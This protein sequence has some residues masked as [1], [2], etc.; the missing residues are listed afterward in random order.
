MTSTSME[1][2]SGSRSWQRLE[3]LGLAA[4]STALVLMLAINRALIPP[5]LVFAILYALLAVGVSRF[6]HKRWVPLGAGVLALLGMLGN[7][8]FLAGDLAHPD[9][10][11]SFI[12]SALVVMGAFVGVVAAVMAR[13]SPNAQ[14]SKPLGVGAAAVAVLLVL[15][16][17]GMTVTASSDA[18][19]AGDVTV[20]AKNVQYPGAVEVSSGGA[21]LVENRDP[22]HHTFVID[23]TNINVDLPADKNRRVEVGLAPGEYHFHCD[24]PGHESMAGTL[25]VG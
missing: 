24:V 4:V 25:T 20:V 7:A 22:I 1:P 3:V 23:D 13:F 9:S 21:L 14:F 8:P 19:Q 17:V 2:T 6:G 12:P 15:L 16:S 18:A 5:V 11:G 10:W